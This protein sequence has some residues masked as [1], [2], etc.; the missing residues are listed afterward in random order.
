ME[1]KTE[2]VAAITCRHCG[3]LHW[4]HKCTKYVPE[5]EETRT[6]RTGA[7]GYVLPQ[8]RGRGSDQ[9]DPE[10]EITT[11]RVSNLSEDC[12][13]DDLRAVFSRYGMI[14]RIYLARDRE[15]QIPK[16][17]AYVTFESRD[18]AER[19]KTGAIGVGLD[20]LIWSI[21]WARS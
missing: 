6:S 13:D 18:E 4:S 3:G 1:E 5:K 20:H 8:R 15:T 16:G 17:F 12:T 7:G 2:N 14:T 11:L 21:E 10:R 9:S 19:A